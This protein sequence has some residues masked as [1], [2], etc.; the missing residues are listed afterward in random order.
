MTKEQSYEQPEMD[1]AQDQ[2][3]EVDNET[4]SE[5]NFIEVNG[6][7]LSID[8]LK[9]GYLRQSDYTKKTQEL[10][11][12][13]KQSIQEAIQ[14]SQ[15]QYEQPEESEEDKLAKEFIN[16]HG[17]LT[18]QEAENLLKKQELA[19]KDEMEFQKYKQ[20]YQ[21]TAA[22]EKV[23]KMLGYTK[24][25]STKSWAEIHKHAYGDTAIERVVS[26]KVVGASPKAGVRAS[27]KLTRADL[28]SM[29]MDEYRKKSPMEW[30]AMLSD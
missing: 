22:Q 17:L 24:E 28:A 4:G 2:A 5:E 15:K 8:E 19:A 20:E 26:K 7:K 10:A 29:P 9:A 21:P 13:R 25:F 11:E 3:Q 27:E 6:E 30:M 23:V 16:Q 12:L 18:K 14:A 1:S